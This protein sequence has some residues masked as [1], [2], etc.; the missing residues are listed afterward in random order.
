MLAFD[1]LKRTGPPY[2]SSKAT[3][4]KQENTSC[5][6][7]QRNHVCSWFSA[8]LPH[9]LL[10]AQNKTESSKSRLLPNRERERVMAKID[11][12]GVV[13]LSALIVFSW[14]PIYQCAK[15]PVGAARKE[16]IPYIKCQV[17]EKLA[18]Q[19]YQQVQDKQAQISPKK[20]FL[21]IEVF[22]LFL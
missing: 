1:W 3:N 19:L 20:V 8:N 7:N 11:R 6:L 17:C 14:V 9:S 16:D 4:Q 18:R 10:R 21:P 5:L 2:V 12:I 15:K 13:V 22:C